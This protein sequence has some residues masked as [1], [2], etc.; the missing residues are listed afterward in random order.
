MR[1]LNWLRRDHEP[2][3][4][5]DPLNIE[6]TASRGKRGRS[7]AYDAM[8]ELEKELKRLSRQQKAV[9]THFKRLTSSNVR[10]IVRGQ[11]SAH[12]GSYELSQAMRDTVDREQAGRDRSEQIAGIERRRDE[13]QN[14]L[15]DLRAFVRTL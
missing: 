8:A 3:A 5:A 1:L 6:A 11:R 12:L 9:D 13:I 10:N 14:A 7:A 4:D 15:R 2:L